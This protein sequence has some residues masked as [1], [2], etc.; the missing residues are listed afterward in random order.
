[1]AW[2]VPTHPHGSGTF[3]I[4][5]PMGQHPSLFY[6]TFQ[7]HNVHYFWNHWYDAEVFSPHFWLPVPSVLSSVSPENRS[8][9]RRYFK[10]S[11]SKGNLQS[12]SREFADWLFSTSREMLFSRLSTSEQ[13]I[14]LGADVSAEIRTSLGFAL[15]QFSDSKVEFVFGPGDDRLES[16]C[17]LEYFWVPLPV[18]L[19]SV[20]DRCTYVLNYVRSVWVS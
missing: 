8:V 5:L 4:N 9:F 6:E 16:C 15:A 11:S 1:M 14:F 13:H 20:W 2:S 18:D 10:T 17:S 7:N 3:R 19:R 12:R